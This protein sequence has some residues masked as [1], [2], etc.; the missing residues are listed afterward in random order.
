[1]LSR[2]AVAWSLLSLTVISSPAV[3]DGVTVGQ[4]APTIQA[5]SWLNAPGEV[6]LASLR[7]KVV[8][9]EFWATWCGPCRKSIPHM[10]A[11]A[12]RLGRKGLVVVGLTREDAQTVRSFMASTK[13]KMNYIVG[14][15]SHSSGVYGGKY[16]PRVFIVDRTGLVFWRGY[17]WEGLDEAVTRALSSVGKGLATTPASEPR[18]APAR[19]AYERGDY[20]I[21]LELA[22][23]IMADK[24][25][26]QALSDGAGHLLVLVLEAG[27]DGLAETRALAKSRKYTEAI[28]SLGD[29]AEQFVG[30]DVG[31]TAKSELLALRKNRNVIAALKSEAWDQN[32]AGIMARADALVERKQYARAVDGY[33]L[34]SSLYPRFAPEARQKAKRLLSDKQITAQAKEQRAITRAV[35]WLTTARRHVR[36]GQ[37]V[38]ARSS[39]RKVIRSYRDT[40][41][42]RAARKELK[43]LVH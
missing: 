26:S 12:N 25:S 23:Q 9:V 3:G 1:M 28:N 41:Y 35:D 32:A 7:G 42:A 13:T 10:N 11:L 8:L 4:K 6:S 21:A 37:T 39:Y 30:T 16:I 20:A 2:H 43:G 34:V 33:K 17:P 5:K 15:E 36:L 14:C 40:S 31:K 19:E 24:A 18:L 38:Q 22:E 29:L 27:R